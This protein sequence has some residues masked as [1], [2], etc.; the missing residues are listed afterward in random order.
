MLEMGWGRARGAEEAG[1]APMCP[2]LPVPAGAV[3]GAAVT[4]L[5]PRRRRRL[6]SSPPPTPPTVNALSCEALGPASHGVPS[7][8]PRGSAAPTS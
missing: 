1:G 5:H 6:P 8:W 3:P 2:Q 4:S 7:A